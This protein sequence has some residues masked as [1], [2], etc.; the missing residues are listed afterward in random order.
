MNKKTE[1]I[2]R[3]QKKIKIKIKKNNKKEEKEKTRRRQGTRTK[4]EE[5]RREKREERRENLFS[6]FDPFWT[7]PR[8]REI[9][10]PL[11]LNRNSS[12]QKVELFFFFSVPKSVV[13]CL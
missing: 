9:L 1:N 7:I 10:S 5:K 8:E 2:E 6:V 11:R 3:P 13:Y 12:R 4:R